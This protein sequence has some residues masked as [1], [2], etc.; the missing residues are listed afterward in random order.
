VGFS[1]SVNLKDIFV[2]YFKTLYQHVLQNLKKMINPHHGIG[3]PCRV[4][5]RAPPESKSETF[6]AGANFLAIDVLAVLPCTTRTAL[7]H[8]ILPRR[9]LSFEVR[10][11][12]CNSRD[13][14][15]LFLIA[16]FKIKLLQSFMMTSFSDKWFGI[17]I[18][19]TDCVT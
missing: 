11:V 3:H 9:R 2:I 6:S 7:Y 17:T 8:F 1:C 14:T 12:T 18:T 15:S 19:E 4:L 10:S 13:S 16:S 5:K